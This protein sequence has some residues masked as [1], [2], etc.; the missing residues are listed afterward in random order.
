[1]ARRIQDEACGAR[2]LDKREVAHLLFVFTG[3]DPEG[4]LT[5]HLTPLKTPNIQQLAV[6][7]HCTQH[8]AMIRAVF[9]EAA[10]A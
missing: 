6:A 1:M 10:R 7:V 5:A 4:K 3:N 8:Q 9:E 2:L